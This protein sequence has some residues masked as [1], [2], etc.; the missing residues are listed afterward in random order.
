MKITIVNTPNTKGA[1]PKW[2]PW[3]IEVPVEIG[4]ND[5]K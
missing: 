1:A 3:M 4:D 2:C 5:K